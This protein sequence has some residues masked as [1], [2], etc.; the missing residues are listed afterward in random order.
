MAAAGAAGSL[1]G[2]SIVRAFQTISQF[3]SPWPLVVRVWSLVVI[4]AIVSPLTRLYSSR[5]VSVSPL[6]PEWLSEHEIA[7]NRWLDDT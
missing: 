2:S 3:I 1:R 7:S 4:A 6:S 5:S